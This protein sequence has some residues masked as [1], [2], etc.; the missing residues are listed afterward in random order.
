MAKDCKPLALKLSRDGASVFVCLCDS[1]PRHH[2][3]CLPVKDYFCIDL[4]YLR[5]VYLSDI[6]IIIIKV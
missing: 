5:Y 3:L 1:I 6:I 2:P 4:D